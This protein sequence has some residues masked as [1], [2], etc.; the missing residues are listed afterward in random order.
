M[1]W[2]APG[3]MAAVCARACKDATQTRQRVPKVLYSA[4][5]A[6]TCEDATQTRQRVPKVLYA[7]ICARACEDVDALGT[8]RAALFRAF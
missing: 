2:V 3:G 1:R 8:R 5:C 6:R 4:I 7:A